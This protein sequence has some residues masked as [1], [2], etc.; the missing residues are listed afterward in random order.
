G[1]MSM[2][3]PYR[4]GLGL[5]VES[6]IPAQRVRLGQ[7]RAHGVKVAASV[8]W[9]RAEAEGASMNRRRFLGLQ[10]AA[11]AAL[12][13]SPAAQAAPAPRRGVSLAGAEFG[14]D[15]G[16][17]SQRSLGVLGRDYTYQSERTVAYFCEQGLGLLRLPVRWERLQ[18]RLGEALDEKELDH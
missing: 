4:I 2:R 1:V 16:G 11:V 8:G 6:G 7:R 14:A 5:L 18:P 15:G 10:A 9:G 3:T 13:R 17:F 12:G